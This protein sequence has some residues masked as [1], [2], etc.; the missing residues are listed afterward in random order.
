M[1]WVCDNKTY[2]SIE[3]Y[4][5]SPKTEVWVGDMDGHFVFNNKPRN[6]SNSNNTYSMDD[7]IE[8]IYGH[9]EKPYVPCLNPDYPAKAKLLAGSYIVQFGLGSQR[10]RFELT[11]DRIIHEGDASSLIPT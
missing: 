11:N 10:Y 9:L 3:I 2:Y 4:P 8:R 5:R 7:A 1:S 6:D